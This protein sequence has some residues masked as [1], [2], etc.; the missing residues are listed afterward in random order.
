MTTSDTVEHEV[1]RLE[2]EVGEAISRR[3][4]AALD[5]LIADDFQVTNP[6]GQVMSKHEA[7]AALASPDY[8]LDSLSNDDIAVRVFGDVAVAT[9]VG[10]ARGRHRGQEASGRFRYLRAWVRRQG[11]WQAVAAQS[12]NLPQTPT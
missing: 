6:S 11:R 4:V 10:T 5:R 1:T 3:D 9:A 2:R 12:T 7:I 8:E